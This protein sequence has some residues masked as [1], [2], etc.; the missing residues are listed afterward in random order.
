VPGSSRVFKLP[1]EEKLIPLI[2]LPF[3]FTVSILG[4]SVKFNV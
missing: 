1:A 3:A 4:H 2:T